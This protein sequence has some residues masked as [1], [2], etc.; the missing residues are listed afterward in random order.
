MARTWQK[1]VIGVLLFVVLAVEL[2]IVSVGLLARPAPADVMI[3]LGSRVF[4]GEPGPML[5][6][7]LDEAVRLYR[8]GFAPAIIVSGAKGDDEEMAEAFA[9]R[10]YLV[11]HGVPADRIHTEAASFN[12]YQNLAYSQAVMVQNGFRTALIVSNASHIRRT[13]LLAR[14]L[15]LEASAAPAPMPD[16]LYL[17]VRQYVR[18]GAAM[19]SLVLSR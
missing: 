7:R 12:T 1:L 6:L 15:G 4:G 8:D 3:V 9:M 19:M 5:R 10:D 2:P 16:S 13:L 14:D 17:R 18:E 11:R